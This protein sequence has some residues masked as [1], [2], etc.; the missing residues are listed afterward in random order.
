[1]PDSGGRFGIPTSNAGD[2]TLAQRL[3][4]DSKLQIDTVEKLGA[5]LLEARLNSPLGLR[6]EPV[7]DTASISC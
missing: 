6:I 3:R 5:D 2:T 7:L 4:A 1:M